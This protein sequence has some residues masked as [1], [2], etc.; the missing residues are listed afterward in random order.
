MFL[1]IEI[2]RKIADFQLNLVNLAELFVKTY[3]Y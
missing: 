2:F 1:D 3:I